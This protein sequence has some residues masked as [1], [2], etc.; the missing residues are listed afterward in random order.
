MSR[1]VF[2]VIE[3]ENPEGLSTRKLV[4]ETAKHNVLTAHSGAEGLAILERH[5]ADAV[6]VHTGIKDIPCNRL[7][8]AIKSLDPKMQVI[9]LA[10]NQ[11]FTCAGADLVL[12][13]HEP[14]RLLHELQKML[15]RAEGRKSA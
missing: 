1:A 9:V 2:V 12:P 5:P 7:V 3:P 11:A 14:D 8:Q 4:L 13:S 6:V 10:P 15:A